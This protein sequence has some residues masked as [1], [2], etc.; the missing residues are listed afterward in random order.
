MEGQG[1][2]FAAAGYTTPYLGP[3]AL[4]LNNS[5]K[6]PAPDAGEEVVKRRGGG[7]KVERKEEKGL[8]DDKIHPGNFWVKR[9]PRPLRNSV[10]GTK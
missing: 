7:G 3:P 10:T 5:P 4:W 2:R 6:P 1:W 9:C 8:N